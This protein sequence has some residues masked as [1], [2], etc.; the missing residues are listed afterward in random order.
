MA[1]G[2][3]GR[4]AAQPCAGAVVVT[5]TAMLAIEGRLV[6]G[7]TARF[8]CRDDVGMTLRKTGASVV[9]LIAAGMAQAEGM[10]AVMAGQ[11]RY[12]G[13]LFAANS[14]F[15]VS[16][17]EANATA[18]KVSVGVPL[19]PNIAIAGGFQSLGRYSRAANDGAN[20]TMDADMDVQ[21]F[22]LEGR[23]QWRPGT[24]VRPYVK[25]SMLFA[26]VNAGYR[27]QSS[28][29]IPLPVQVLEREARGQVM[30]A[31]GIGLM[32]E[33]ST[34]WGLQVEFERFSGIEGSPSLRKQDADVMA[35]GAYLFW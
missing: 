22:F 2:S 27:L 31:P 15:S 25:L 32:L 16:K 3:T 17:D 30:L 20:L 1:N 6:F 18:L 26:D 23:W 14:G 5:V 10:V 28:A 13:E 35:V 7:N 29:A 34:G 24:A 12:S 9:L 11:A 8:I 4:G 33:P 21:G 19:T